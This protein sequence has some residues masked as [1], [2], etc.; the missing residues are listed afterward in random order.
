MIGMIYGCVPIVRKVGGLNDTVSN[1]NPK[2]EKGTGFVFSQFDE[3]HLFGCIIRALENY[4]GNGERWSK[5]VKKAMNEAN[6]WSIPAEK[7]IKLYKKVIKMNGS[8]K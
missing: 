6:D 4:F 3:F 1:Y 7:Y 8:R 2:T 5:L